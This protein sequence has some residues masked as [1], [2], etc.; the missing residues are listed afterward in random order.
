MIALKQSFDTEK[1]KDAIAQNLFLYANALYNMTYFGNGRFIASTPIS[2]MDNDYPD[3]V[4]EEAKIYKY[5][6]NC[7]EALAYYNKARSISTDKEF[8]AKCAWAAA[9]CEHNLKLTG[10]L[11]WQTESAG[12]FEAGTYFLEM[13]NNYAGTKYYKE[14]LN[15]CGY[16]C[17]YI[18]KD[19]ACIRDKWSLRNR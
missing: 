12:D 10:G 4:K 7:S 2:W 5:Y 17:T 8:A 16:F 19:N 18:T 14:V 6:Y 15:E 3:D 13:R 1:N 11:P 9:K